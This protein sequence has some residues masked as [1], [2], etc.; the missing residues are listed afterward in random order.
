MSSPQSLHFPPGTERL[1]AGLGSEHTGF[2]T[3]K[4]RGVQRLQGFETGKEVPPILYLGSA[5]KGGSAMISFPL[6]ANRCSGTG[7]GP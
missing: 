1:K 3:W 2:Q 4:G 7:L 5:F 6:Q